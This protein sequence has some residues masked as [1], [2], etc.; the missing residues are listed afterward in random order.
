[1]YQK[2]III[3]VTIYV[4]NFIPIYKFCFFLYWAFINLLL[5]LQQHLF[6]WALIMDTKM[7]R[8]GRRKC[9]ED[10]HDLSSFKCMYP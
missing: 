4:Y 9:I 2:N 10:F 7:A 1:M 6:Y 5:L 3:Y 8:R